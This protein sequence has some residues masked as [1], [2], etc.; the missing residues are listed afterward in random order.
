MQSLQNAYKA[1]DQK[2]NEVYRDITARVTVQVQ[3]GTIFIIILQL[4]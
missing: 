4:T 2:I 3:K 1:P